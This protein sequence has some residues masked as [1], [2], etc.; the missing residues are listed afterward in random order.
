MLHYFS[1]LDKIVLKNEQYLKYVEHILLEN[2]YGNV[3]NLLINFS[4]RSPEKVSLI[5]V[6][7]LFQFSFILV[8]DN[9]IYSPNL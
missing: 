9:F 4:L 7:N 1:I 2:N 8:G 3:Q 6:I 5:I